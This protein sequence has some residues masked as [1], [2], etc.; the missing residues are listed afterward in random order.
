MDEHVRGGVVG[1]GHAQDARQVG[2]AGRHN[3][4]GLS[5]ITETDADG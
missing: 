1:P 5:V 4:G 2:Q 3:N